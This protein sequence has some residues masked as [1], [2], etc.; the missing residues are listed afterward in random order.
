[1]A[2][3]PSQTHTGPIAY[4]PD[5]TL[6]EIIGKD[7]KLSEI[8]TPERIQACQKTIADA[9]DSFFTVAEGDIVKLEKLASDHV[10]APDI[11]DDIFED[12]SMLAGNIKGH[13]DL[14]GFTLV[15]AIGKHI[16]SFCELKV[17]SP[18]TRFRVIADLIK[19]QRVAFNH[20][21]M[22]ERGALAKELATS[23]QKFLA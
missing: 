22:D 2:D 12:V 16:I 8:F 10:M 20:K 23:L 11:S 19:M 14:F 15:S 5:Q 3:K 18:S 9:R 1:M 13:A 17:R 21:V 7:T 6:R 4:E